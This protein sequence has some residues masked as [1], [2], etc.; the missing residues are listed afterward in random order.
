MTGCSIVRAVSNLCWLCAFVVLFTVGP[1]RA[2]AYLDPGTG[3]VVLQGAIAAVAGGI[4]AMRAYWHGIVGLFRKPDR[5]A[6]KSPE[7]PADDDA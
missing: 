7:R 2:Y 6:S 5:A 3:S 4:L 1:T